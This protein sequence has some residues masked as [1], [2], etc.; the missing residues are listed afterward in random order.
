MGLEAT[1]LGRDGQPARDKNGR[2]RTVKVRANRVILSGGAMSTPKL[3]LQQKLGNSSGQVGRNL[4]LHPSGP[5]VALFEELVEGHRYIPQTAY[6]HQFLK[7]G[8][9]LLSA[10]ADANMMPGMTGLLG[11]RLMHVFEKSDHIACMGFLLA[12][13]ARGRIRVDSKGRSLMTYNLTARDVQK[14][15]RAQVLCSELLFAA[16]AKEVYPGINPGITL[17][18]RRGLEEFSRRK[19]GAGDFLLASYHP[20]GTCHMSPSPRAGVVGLD[21][22]VHDVPGLYVVDGST[23]SGPLGVNPQLSIMALATRAA[24]KIGARME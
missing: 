2:E 22:Q 6:S 7:E 24:E 17:F 14:M 18:D 11:R 12:E 13:E 21:H 3:L 8:L 20:L 5:T 10:H 23:V 15:H 19:L 1:V 4:T 9:M 16:G